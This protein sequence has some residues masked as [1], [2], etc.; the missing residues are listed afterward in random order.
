MNDRNPNPNSLNANDAF[1]PNGSKTGHQSPTN[2]TIDRSPAPDQTL[3]PPPEQPAPTRA[4]SD[5]WSHVTKDLLDTLPQIWTR[6]LFYLL[7]VSTVILVPWSVLSKVDETGSAR[8][9]LEPQGKTLQ[10]DAPVAGTVASVKVDEGSHVKTGQVLLELEADTTR[11]DLQQAESKQEG[12]LDRITQL[13]VMKNQLEVATRAQRLQNQAQAS[14]QQAQIAQ[15]LQEQQFKQSAYQLNQTLLNKNQETLERFR[16]AQQEGVV[17]L[18]QLE[19]TERAMIESQRLLEQTRSEVK[20]SKAELTRQQSTYEGLIR[21]GEVAVLGSQKQI[22][23]LQSQISDTQAEIAQVKSQ[24]HSLQ[25]QLQQRVLHAPIDGAVFQLP[26]KSAGAV[27]QPG[28]L[29][30]EIAPKGSPLILNAQMPSQESGFLR[31]GMPAKIKLDAYPF[32]DYG[33]LQ[34]R[35]SWVSPDSKVVE[36]PQGQV[37]MFDLKI[38]VDRPYIEAENRRID[39]TPGQTATAEVIVRQRRIIDLILDPLKKLQQGGL[40]L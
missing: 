38:A 39:L 37:E 16:K 36:T 18:L 30:A 10:L 3:P 12:L 31:V 32:Q 22:E 27:V 2:L 25:F 8:G 17:S 19:E 28:E 5:E 23:E 6:G 11:A 21:E 34:G 40:K 33:I 35:V 7:A 1:H 9:R 24:I 15:T 29:L 13:Q 4:P 26:V 20:Q 14:A